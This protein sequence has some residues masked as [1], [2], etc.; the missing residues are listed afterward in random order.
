MALT[1]LYREAAR[2]EIVEAARIYERLRPGFGSAFLDEIARVEGHVSNAPGLYQLVE[3]E[4][5]RVTLRRF[6]YGLFYLG[7]A[8]K[9]VVLAC[10]DLRRDPKAIRE[11]I[12]RR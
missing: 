10:L 11:I 3:L 1:V 8:E 4:I 12:G 5:R 9:I 2:R 7:E 6:P